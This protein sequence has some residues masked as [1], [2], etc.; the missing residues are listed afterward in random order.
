M[1]TLRFALCLALYFLLRLFGPAEVSLI[2]EAAA[3]P[4]KMTPDELYLKCRNAMFRR[5]GHRVTDDGRQKL[6][7]FSDVSVRLVDECVRRNNWRTVR[8]PS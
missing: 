2:S 4:A 3:Q 5:Y 1:R 6:A 7:M 8:A